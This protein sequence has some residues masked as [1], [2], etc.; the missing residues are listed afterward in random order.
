MAEIELGVVVDV[1]VEDAA[2]LLGK[3]VVTVEERGAV[4]DALDARVDVEGVDVRRHLDCRASV[5]DEWFTV[6][7]TAGD[8]KPLRCVA[9]VYV[10]VCVLS[11]DIER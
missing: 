3:V 7:C 11:T 8:L 9:S 1:A 2:G 6:Y 10:R 4:E 5:V